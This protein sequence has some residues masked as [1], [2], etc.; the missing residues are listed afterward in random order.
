ML[1]GEILL[2]R[3]FQINWINHADTHKHHSAEFVGW[4]HKLIMKFVALRINVHYLYLYKIYL[5][6]GLIG[7][8]FMLPVSLTV[9]IKEFS[10]MA[11]RKIMR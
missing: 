7:V 5:Y 8:L 2:V 10:G 6:K 11:I 9:I 4:N 3:N 1:R